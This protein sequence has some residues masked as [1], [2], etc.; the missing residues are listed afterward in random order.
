MINFDIKEGKT[1]INGNY[2]YE[3][4]QELKKVPE[5][6]FDM[7]SDEWE[8]NTEY[9]KHLVSILEEMDKDVSHVIPELNHITADTKYRG[10]TEEEK[11]KTIKMKVLKENAKSLNI[12]FDYDQKV[13]ETVKQIEG[14]AFNKTNKSWRI[15]KGNEDWLYSKLEELDYIDLSDLLPYTSYNS[16]SEISLDKSNFPHL[17][18]TPYDFQWDAIKQLLNNKKMINALEAGLGKTIITIMV[19]EYLKKK[20]L[21]ITPASVKYNWEKEILEKVNPNADITV[22]DSKSEWR[23][24]QYVILNY[25]ILENFY[26][27]IMKSN[28]EIVAYDEAHKLRGVDG[29]GKPS[30]KR[31]R[32]GVKIAEEMEYV[33][34]ITA[35]PYV[36][37]TKDIFNLLKVIE[38]PVTTNWYQFANSYCGATKSHF[39]T[40]YN[41]SSNQEDL[42]SRL[43]PNYMLRMRTEDHIDLPERIRS[44]IPV[45]INMNKYKKAVNNYMDNRHSLETNGQHLVYLNAM[46]KELAIAKA[47]HAIDHVKDLLEQN[48]SVVIFTNFKDVVDT[49]SKKFENNSVKVTGEVNAKDRQKAVDEFQSGKKKVFIGNIDAAGEGI[50]LTESHHMIVVD[51]HWSPVVMVNQME[52]RINRIGQNLPCSIDYLYSKEADMDKMFLSMLEDKLNDSTMIIDGKKE[53]FL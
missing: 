34:P 24:S 1:I 32:L 4:Y 36:N 3:L 30:S 52:K 14:R 47:K 44:F 27:D 26:D 53:E 40:N 8:I 48:K 16:K 6:S 29:K 38:H 43:Y 22:L 7:Y 37:Q 12:G 39:G 49:L 35:T 41:G 45:D 51:F 19:A 11:I 20:T 13:L 17:K 15:A 50:T 25:D 2:D 21:I 9:L 46:R 5:S 23:D 18:I 33:F 28:F 42:N 10:E 31:A